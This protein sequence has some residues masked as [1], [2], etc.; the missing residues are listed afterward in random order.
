MVQYWKDTFVQTD[1]EED[2]KT[3]D[4]FN[5]AEPLYLQKLEQ[6]SDLEQP[7]LSINSGHI[8]IFDDDL[9]RQLVCY[10]QEV[11][12]FRHFTESIYCIDQ[13]VEEAIVWWNLNGPKT[14][15]FF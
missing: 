10:P 6:I 12:S 9:Y 4:G 14:Q 1:A 2:E 5:P 13:L 8:K 7:Y 11:I 15:E 3:G